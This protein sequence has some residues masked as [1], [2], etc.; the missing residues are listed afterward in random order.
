[1]NG[2]D[3]DTHTMCPRKSAPELMFAMAG[4]NHEYPP[5]NTIQIRRGLWD[6]EKIFVYSACREYI[7]ADSRISVHKYPYGMDRRPG[8]MIF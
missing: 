7:S 3:C 1:M 4:M 6:K 8:T 2:P 5:P